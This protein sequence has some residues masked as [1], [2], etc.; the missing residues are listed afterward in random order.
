M[1]SNVCSGE[2]LAGAVEAG[3]ERKDVEPHLVRIGGDWSLWKWVGLRGAGFPISGISQLAA[4]DCAAHADCVMAAEAH[5]EL[6][7][8][9]AIDSLHS[10]LA[11]VCHAD[12]PSLFKALKLIKKGK[13]VNQPLPGCATSAPVE[14]FAEAHQLKEAKWEQYN[15]AYEE[16]VKAGSEAVRRI[17][18][19]ERFR[20]AIAWQNHRALHTGIDPILKKLPTAFQDSKD[21]RNEELIATYW[22]RYCTK[23]DTIGFFGP[24]GWAR[25]TS[26]AAAI[27]VAAG[28]HL[29][30]ARKVYFETWCIDALAESLANDE[31]IKPWLAPRLV[32]TVRLQGNCLHLPA[33][34]RHQLSQE[35]ALVLSNCNGHRLAVEIGQGLIG[36]SSSLLD[37][38]QQV[39]DVLEELRSRGLI[40][41]SIAVPS[42]PDPE[43]HLRRVISRIADEP[44]RKR[45]MAVVDELD[46]ARSRVAAAA[47]SARELDEAMHELERKFTGLTGSPAARQE[48]KMYAGRTLVY[49]DC[50]R[51]IEVELGRAE[52][53]ELGAALSLVLNSA[54]WLIYQAAQSFRERLKQIYAQLVEETGSASI[55]SSLFWGKAQSVLYKGES[56]LGAELS[57]EFQRR[58]ARVLRIN[59]TERQQSYSSE[60]ISKSAEEEFGP[61]GV[62]WQRARYHSPDV[63]IAA[64]S[65]DAI[66][67]GDYLL[68]LGELHMAINSLRASLFVNQ[69]PC[70]D[71]LFKSLEQDMHHP[72]IV[73]VFSKKGPTARG[74]VTLISPKDY[75][76]E[77]DA[78]SP[79]P[80]KSNVLAIGSLVIE[81]GGNG[82]VVRSLDGEFQIDIIEAFS[83]RLTYQMINNF[84]IMP[85]SDHAPRITIDKLVVSRE[86]WQFDAQGL[87][88]AFEKSE[89]RRFLQVR[90]WAEFAGL[91]RHVFYKTALE[92]KPCYLDLDSPLLINIFAKQ[93][94]RSA[95]ADPHSRIAVSEMLPTPQQVWL[96]DREGNLYT[97]ELRLVAIDGAKVNQ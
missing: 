66:R 2:K 93:I 16:A 54:K 34:A 43:R 3:G 56:G 84:K 20:E 28:P 49:E 37:T 59:H 51:D 55:N 13:V 88:F 75:L 11:T 70:P 74:V 32:P 60:E 25:L 67:R 97:C 22:Q 76:L 79:S 64:T 87:G 23:N 50:R 36:E 21:R 39:F 92:V 95:A 68:V 9:Q 62:G 8:R 1:E 38:Q 47:G 17:A 27:S 19:D 44:L 41:W 15:R 86:S 10:D 96:P 46:E 69:H 31:D 24:V 5:C 80:L 77:F 29:L 35:Q 83:E 63:M 52:I 65:V 53:A 90:R 72:C 58:W 45:C 89:A 33:G 6:F 91:P 85:A 30:A 61:A 42:S 18:A 57:K 14:R 71:E 78:N 73:P 82:L 40:S 48:G 12:R 4:T 94:R 7:R 81:Q 26:A